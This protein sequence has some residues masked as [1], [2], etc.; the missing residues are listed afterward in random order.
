MLNQKLTESLCLLLLPLKTLMA[1]LKN[2]LNPPFGSFF[3]L[4]TERR[5]LPHIFVKV[6]AYNSMHREKHGGRRNDVCRLLVGK[7]FHP[8]I[9]GIYIHSLN[10]NPRR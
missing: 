5:H 9:E 7:L 6:A 1:K 4:R 8:V 2:L 10:G 3:K